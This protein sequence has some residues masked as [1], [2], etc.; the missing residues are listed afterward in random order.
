MGID[1][2]EQTAQTAATSRDEYWRVGDQSSVTEVAHDRR[3]CT[4][5]FDAFLPNGLCGGYDS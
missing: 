1:P 2:E 4:L 3:R 5:G